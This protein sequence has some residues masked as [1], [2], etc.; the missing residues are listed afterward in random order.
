MNEQILDWL[1][2]LGF[3]KVEPEYLGPFE[4]AMGLFCRGREVIREQ[5]DI[6][7]RRVCRQKAVF[8]VAV[9]TGDFT[10]LDQI[11]QL[12]PLLLQT[13]PVFGLDQRIRLEKGRTVKHNGSAIP[14]LEC[15]LTVEYTTKEE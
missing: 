7:G 10:A 15:Q 4:G 8:L 1:R 11:L 2:A 5:R 9:R 12:E 13:A 3:P 6:L 14:V